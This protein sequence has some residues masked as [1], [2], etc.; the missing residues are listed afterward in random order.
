MS[1]CQM[2]MWSSYFNMLYNPVNYVT[3]CEWF[4]VLYAVLILNF[5]L[6]LYNYYCSIWWKISIMLFCPII[7]LDVALLVLHDRHYSENVVI[8]VFVEVISLPVLLTG[9]ELQLS[10]HYSPRST[11]NHPDRRANSAGHG[12]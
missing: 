3:V 9:I 6:N 2:H 1:I 12:E 8:V 7:C 11:E 10:H 5:L 4:D